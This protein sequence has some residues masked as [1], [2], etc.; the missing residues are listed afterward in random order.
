MNATVF[1]CACVYVCNAWTVFLAFC[2]HARGS[3]KHQPCFGSLQPQ[4]RDALMNSEVIA[5]AEE[6]AISPVFG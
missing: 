3:M 6:A 2:I 1:M 5:G 4:N